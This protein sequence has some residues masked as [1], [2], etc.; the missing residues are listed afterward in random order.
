MDG[1][2][3]AAYRHFGQTASTS[4]TNASA[5]IVYDWDDIDFNVVV[6]RRGSRRG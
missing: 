5:R 2:L 1:L 4:P 6:V 3:W